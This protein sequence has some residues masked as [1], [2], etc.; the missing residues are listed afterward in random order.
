MGKVTIQWWHL[1][2][3]NIA[4]VDFTHDFS[5]WRLWFFH[6]DVNVYHCN[7]KSFSELEGIPVLGNLHMVNVVGT[8]W[9]HVDQDYYYHHYYVFYFIFICT[10]LYHLM[11]MIIIITIIMIMMYDVTLMGHATVNLW[12]FNQ[13][14]SVLI[15]HS[16]PWGYAN[17][18]GFYKMN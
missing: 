7:A 6:N 12:M 10:G 14:C 3:E 17:M 16:N 13:R 15:D 5:H 8:W 11:M 18:L 4:I 1:S 9:K 2:I